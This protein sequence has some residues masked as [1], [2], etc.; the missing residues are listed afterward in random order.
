[1]ASSKEYLSMKF[2]SVCWEGEVA[3][4]ASPLQWSGKSAISHVTGSMPSCSVQW[5]MT[6]SAPP[7]QYSFDIPPRST[8]QVIGGGTPTAFLQTSQ[9]EQ[10][11]I[12]HH[13]TK[14]QRSHTG[15]WKGRDVCWE[16][17]EEAKAHSIPGQL[18]KPLLT[19]WEPTTASCRL[20]LA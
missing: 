14:A 12:S 3:Y 20:A 6:Y 18:L 15:L 4:E 16:R 8:D 11:N 7:S 9:M 5:D 10:L 13:A 17:K 1:M 19:W 2:V